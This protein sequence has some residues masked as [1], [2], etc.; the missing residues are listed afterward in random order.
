MSGYGRHPWSTLKTM[1]ATDV[2]K[3]NG[4]KVSRP[5]ELHY[6][7]RGSGGLQSETTTMARCDPG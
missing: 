2:E 4:S 1:V 3:S 6:E 7:T 5:G